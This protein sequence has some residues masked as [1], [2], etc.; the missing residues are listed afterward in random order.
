LWYRLVRGLVIT[1][2]LNR[3]VVPVS[4]WSGDNC[5]VDSACGTG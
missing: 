2:M 5:N 3:L 4:T 1:V